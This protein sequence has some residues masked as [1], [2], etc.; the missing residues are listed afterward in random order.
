M[1][2]GEISSFPEIYFLYNCYCTFCNQILE[3]DTK[4]A[5]ASQ[6]WLNISSESILEFLNMERLRIKEADLVRALIRWG[7]Y[8]LLQESGGG[9]NLR[10]KILP[11]FRHIRFDSLSQ[12]E[13]AQLFKEEL[14]EVLTAAEKCSIFM[15]I[16][17]NDWKMMPTDIVSSSKL[18]PRHRPVTYKRSD[19]G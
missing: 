7:K 3:V 6:D 16:I 17:T 18:T 10:S 11:G 19:F 13:V 2:I 5:L 12:Q 8:Q 14:G 1:Q 9:E 15:S 4:E